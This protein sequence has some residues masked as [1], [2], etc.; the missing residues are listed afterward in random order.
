MLWSIWHSRV[1]NCLCAVPALPIVNVKMYLLL[2]G[3]LY[4]HEG[5]RSLST[6]LIDTPITSMGLDMNDTETLTYMSHCI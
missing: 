5:D 4:V 6:Y 3:V 1:R 2:R